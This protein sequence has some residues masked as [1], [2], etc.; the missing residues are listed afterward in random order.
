MLNGWRGILIGN[1]KQ[2]LEN[3]RNK[4]VRGIYKESASNRYVKLLSFCGKTSYTTGR[5]S[6]K[7][8]VAGW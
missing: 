2:L 1:Q 6:N 7:D 4:S 5:M 3:F 8:D